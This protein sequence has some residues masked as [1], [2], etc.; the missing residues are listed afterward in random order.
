MQ[1]YFSGDFSRCLDIMNKKIKIAIYII[2]AIC[3]TLLAG[4]IYLHEVL[5]PS[6][7]KQAVGS[8]VDNIRSAP[9]GTIFNEL[10]KSDPAFGDTTHILDQD[11]V[12]QELYE[13]DNRNK[14]ITY[15]ASF[16]ELMIKDEVFDSVANLFE[17]DSVRFLIN[18]SNNAKIN[19]YCL[20]KENWEATILKQN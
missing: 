10:T 4:T 18:L 19:G 7:L 13:K 8:V 15:S 3:I 17:I 5:L 16:L 1:V 12:I 2:A 11:I 20:F 6:I 9:A 14:I